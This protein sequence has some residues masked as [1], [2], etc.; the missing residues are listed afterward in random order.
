MR[1]IH[2]SLALIALAFSACSSRQPQLLAV[3]PT[4]A[5]VIGK[6]PT[7]NSPLGT[8]SGSDGEQKITL[9]FGE[10]GKLL[11]TSAAGVEAGTWIKAGSGIIKLVTGEYRGQL[12]MLDYRSASLTMEGTTIEVSR[13]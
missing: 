4:P 3:S 10:G 11:F 6:A 2:L 13:Q 5:G 8:W 7:A 1:P 12:T 9:K